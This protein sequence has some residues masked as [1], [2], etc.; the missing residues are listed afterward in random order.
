MPVVKNSILVKM[1]DR[2]FA[3]LMSGPNLNCRPH[4]SRQRI[5]WTQFARFQ[6]L[7]PADALKQLLS[8][9]QI[10][11]W[12]AN[13]VP[14]KRLDKS[15]DGSMHAPSNESD[16][17]KS[18]SDNRPIK[19]ETLSPEEQTHR[20][21]W[22]AQ[23]ALL[24]KVRGLAED[25]R[26]YEQ[27]TGVHVLHVGFPLL[28]LPPAVSGST[29]GGGG[30]SKRLLAPIAFV[31]VSLELRAGLHPVISVGGLHDGADFLM[32]NEALFAWL[33]R[34]TGQKILP[35][36]SSSNPSPLTPLSTPIEDQSVAPATVDAD[37]EQLLKDETNSASISSADPWIELT[38]LVGRV[39]KA[40]GIPTTSLSA[41]SMSELRSAP[42]TDDDNPQA[43]IVLAAVLGLFPM[44][45][46]GLLRD[47][48]AM[49][50]EPSLQ[51]PVENFLT[52]DSELESPLDDR[53]RTPFPNPS[54][55]QVHSENERLITAADPCQAR[56]VR[57]ARDCPALVVHGPPG[58]GKSQTIANM[59]G[60]HLI[61]GERVLLVCDKRTALDVVASRL[62][63]LGLG[64]LY[65]LVHD[66]Q[67]DQRNLYKKAREQL[68]SLT[69]TKV[70]EIAQS[71]LHALDQKLQKSL[72]QLS[73]AWSMVMQRDP[74][75]GVSFHE[76]MGQWLETSN[77]A[78]HA[79]SRRREAGLADGS[80]KNEL[81][82][83]ERR[84]RR[85]IDEPTP[86]AADANRVTLTQFS[87]HENELRN[88]IT[89]AVAI[90]FA[91]HPWRSC[92]A[93][94]L[95][96]FLLKPQSKIQED[97]RAIAECAEYVDTIYDPA[98]PSLISTGWST[99]PY[100]QHMPDKLPGGIGPRIA[101]ESDVDLS[102]AGF[103]AQASARQFLAG[104]LDR[105][106]NEV[107]ADTRLQ[108]SN[109]ARSSIDRAH[110][111]RREIAKLVAIVRSEPLDQQLLF[112]FRTIHPKKPR[113]C[114]PDC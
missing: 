26:E 32:P 101:A 84:K 57:L 113:D 7:S 69:S 23:Q 99:K 97:L 10:T 85:R 19:N 31:P 46:Q 56:A 76:Q 37:E 9:K 38:D 70:N 80:I 73:E 102:P 89:R 88:L 14:P 68:E 13:V 22:S 58:T 51:G 114:R 28:S 20:E 50:A 93:M 90:G 83:T 77:L 65:S 12:K 92:A 21:N 79:E 33:E 8:D 66:P 55:V 81:T 36:A 5:D 11:Q 48:Q 49:I 110:S 108:W 44:N 105:C 98:A 39:A 86:E 29:K 40:L 61:R 96:T 62:D 27:D 107:N 15:V 100:E 3:G 72:D 103:P 24:A 41:D 91:Q 74:E 54:R 82:P 18:R 94:S 16:K 2:L 30:G 106:L 17:N 109:A 4:S 42:R 60:D 6:D 63:S 95:A 112:L 67:H 59:I 75:R 53:F 52:I 47:I 87:A 78:V 43:E 35:E 25:A 34:K 1:L 45:K 64:S 104:R 111:S 71:Q